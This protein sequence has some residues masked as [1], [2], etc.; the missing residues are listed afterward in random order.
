MP[1]L[2]PPVRP[3]DID[4]DGFERPADA[5]PTLAEDVDGD[6]DNDGC[7]DSD[8]DSDG[9]DDQVDKCPDAAEDGG[10]MNHART[11]PRGCGGALSTGAR[12]GA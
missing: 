5:C 2:A 10:P 12:R 6:R 7:P 1:V 9:I 11:R 4:G 3:A 8:R